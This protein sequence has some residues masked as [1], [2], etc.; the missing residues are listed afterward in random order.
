MAMFRKRMTQDAVELNITAFMNLMVILVPFLLITAVFSKL[1]VIDL[2]LPPDGT[3]SSE[4]DQSRLNLQLIVE[5]SAIELNETKLGSLGRFAIDANGIDWQP[6][7]DRLVQIKQRSPQADNITLLFAKEVP[8]RTMITAMDKVR[9]VDLASAGSV[10][11]YELF[12]NI[13]IGDLQT[14]STA[15]AAN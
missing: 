6:V 11:T 5:A 15:D 10:D 8:Y 12:P 3:N 9:N 4:E 13:S 2:N 1:T 14:V 7:V